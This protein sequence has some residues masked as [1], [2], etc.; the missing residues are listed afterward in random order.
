M[1]VVCNSLNVYRCW[2]SFDLV[3]RLF[4]YLSCTY[5]T[6]KRADCVD[7]WVCTLQ[8]LAVKGGQLD[9]GAS[10]TKYYCIH[11][12]SLLTRGWTSMQLCKS[13]ALIYASLIM[14][15]IFSILYTRIMAVFT[16]SSRQLLSRKSDNA[17]IG[18]YSF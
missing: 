11:Q 8:R 13:W 9:K 7:T 14:G 18:L 4:T 5:I 3:A 1:A 10:Q 6:M 17:N 12:C 16:D 15:I 2:L